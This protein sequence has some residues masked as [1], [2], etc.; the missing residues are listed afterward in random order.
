M[1]NSKQHHCIIGHNVQAAVVLF[2]YYLHHCFSEPF[3][4]VTGASNKLGE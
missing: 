3:T 1:Y 4:L 2:N